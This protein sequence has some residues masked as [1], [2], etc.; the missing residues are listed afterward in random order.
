MENDIPI[1]SPVRLEVLDDPAARA[2]HAHEFP[3]S[4]FAQSLVELAIRGEVRISAG[5]TVAR[6]ETA[7]TSFRRAAL[8]SGAPA[9]LDLSSAL[10]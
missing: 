1:G 8:T 2:A 10:H 7:A 6:A 9:C 5:E 3:D 4:T